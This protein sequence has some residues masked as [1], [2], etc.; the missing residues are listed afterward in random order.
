MQTKHIKNMMGRTPLTRHIYYCNF[1]VVNSIGLKMKPT[2]HTSVFDIKRSIDKWH[3]HDDD[4]DLGGVIH[5]IV[6]N[7]L[8]NVCY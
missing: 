4:D 2:N 1:E 8:I 5:F 7:N 3:I 6:L